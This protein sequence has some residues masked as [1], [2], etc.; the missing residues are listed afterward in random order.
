M[1]TAGIER[2]TV[3]VDESTGGGGEGSALRLAALVGTSSEWY[4]FFLYATAAAVV[5]P[6]TFFPNTLD[7]FVA[8][9]AS[10]ST[11]AVGF[12]ARPLGAVFFGHL[13][14]RAGRKTAF[15]TA[16]LIMGL[17]TTVIGLLPPYTRIGAFAPLALVL[18]RLVQGFAVGGQWGGALLLATE[19]APGSK[20]GVSAGIAQAGVP[21][22]VV[23]ANLAFLLASGVTSPAAFM[24]YAWRIPFVASLALVGLAALIQFR[25]QDTAAFREV[26]DR[27]EGGS[28]PV[29][30]ALR[31]YPRSIL[32]A[33]GA[34]I[35]GMLAFYILITYVVAYGVSAGGLQMPRNVML[36]AVLIANVSMIP[37]ELVA[38]RLSDIYGRRR[39]LTIGQVLLAAWSFALFPLMQT[40]SFLWI[41]VAITVGQALVALIHAP[42]SALMAELFSVQVRYSAASLAYQISSVI[43]ASVAPIVASALYARYHDNTFISIYMAVACVISLL[44]VAVVGRAHKTD[45]DRG[46]AVPAKF[47]RNKTPYID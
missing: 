42:V 22:G 30:T 18:L 7:P 29:L 17:A 3:A 32:V 10:F 23:L 9:L 41:T 46:L 44:C 36:G 45:L 27:P 38:G 34:N 5:F 28:S 12:V 33:A 31:L 20:R 1:G 35:S 43:G 2:H 26:R 14:D 39:I 40:R 15:A 11:F 19:S 21:F 4:D 24:A 16:L 25:L 13:G 6:A 37:G 8:L 47:S